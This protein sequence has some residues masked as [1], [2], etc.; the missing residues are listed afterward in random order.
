MPRNFSRKLSAKL[1][2]KIVPK[3]CS[4]KLVPEASLELLAF[5]SPSKNYS[6]KF[7]A[8][9]CPKF[10][11]LQRKSSS[12]LFRKVSQS[13]SPKLFPQAAPQN[14]SPKIFSKIV[15]P[16]LRFCKPVYQ[17]GSQK[18]FCKMA[19]ESCSPKLLLRA[20]PRNGKSYFP[21]LFINFTS[22][23]VPQN[24]Y[25]L[26]PKII[27]Q[28]RSPKLFSKIIPQ[29]Y[30]FSKYFLLNIAAKFQYYLS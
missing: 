19:P 17:N 6:P 4:P 14:Y 13:Y 26:F 22:K 27:P 9:G 29:N 5:H 28:S 7:L 21:K 8:N 30:Y 16:K 18:L 25:C 10:A 12:K 2:F 11:I 15:A 20:T 24:C 3:I 23:I 1:F